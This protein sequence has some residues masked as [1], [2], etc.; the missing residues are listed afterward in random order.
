[1]EKMIFWCCLGGVSVGGVSVA[2]SSF[3]LCSGTFLFS[4]FSLF[5]WLCASFMLLG[6]DVVAEAGLIGISAI[7]IYAIYREKKSKW[8]WFMPCPPCS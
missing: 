3:D 7:L 1:M 6:H 2:V 5:F 4:N 8:N